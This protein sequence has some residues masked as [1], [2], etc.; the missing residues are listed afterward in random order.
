MNAIIGAYV[1]GI[2]T[3]IILLIIITL[4]TIKLV[5]KNA[6]RKWKKIK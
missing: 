3:G 6:E 2:I 5:F 4:I 1:W